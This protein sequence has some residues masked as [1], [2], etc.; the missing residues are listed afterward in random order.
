MTVT[1]ATLDVTADAQTKVYG[2][3]DP[4]LTY[5]ATGFQFSDNEAS[6][7]T[8]A[9]TRAAGEQVA[10][11][12]Y[13][14]NQGTLAANSDYTISFTGN[15]LTITP[16]TLDV[17]ADAQTKVYGAAD[18]TLTYV[19]TGFQFSDNETSVLTGALTRAAGEDVA[20]YAIG[21]G[22]LA[23]NSDYT[24]TFTGNSLTITPATLS[25]AADAQTKVY[26]QA[27]PTLTYVATGFQFSDNEAT[28]LTGALSRAAGEDVASY[29]IGQGTLA[30]NSDYTI[31]FTGNSL[32]ITPATL[33]VAADAQT[34]VYGQADPTLTYVATGFQF[35]DNEATVLTGALSRAVGEDVASYAIGQGTLAANSDYTISFTGNSLTITPATLSVAADVQTKVYGQADPA[36]TYVATG[37]QFSD[38]EATVLTGALSRAAGEDVASYAIG[39]G[40]LAANSDYTISFTGNSL[41]ITPATLDVTADAQTK[42]YGA[43][44]PTLTYV[45]TGFQFSD[46][47]TSVLTGAL[48]RAAGEDVASYAIGQGTLA[49]NSD[50]TISFTGNSLTITP[51]TLVSVSAVNISY[52]T[53]LVNTQLSGSASEAGTPVAGTFAYN[54]SV[55]GTVLRANVAPQSEPVIFTPTDTTDYNTVTATAS[56]NVSKA[57]LSIGTVYDSLTYGTTLGYATNPTTVEDANGNAVSGDFDYTDGTM[58]VTDTVLNVGHYD[59]SVTFYPTDTTDYNSVTTTASIDITK[60]Q[61]QITAANATR[62]YGQDNPDLTSKIYIAQGTGWVDTGQSWTADTT[63]TTNSAVGSYAIQPTEITDQAFL[64]NYD[65]SYVTGELT[66]TP[67]PLTVTGITASDKVY[68]STTTATLNPDGAALVG[69]VN[70]D[71]V[72]LNTGGAAGIFASND[73]NTNITVQVSGLTISGPQA[74]DYTLTQPTT[75]A[76]I[77]PALLTVTGI[78]AANKVYDGGTTAT[79]DTTSAL[80][81]GVVDHEDVTLDATGATGAFADKNVA[82][83][84]VVQVSGL[85]ITGAAIG[86]YTLAQPTTTANITARAITVTAVTDTKVYDGTTTSAATPAITVGTLAPGDTANFTEAFGNKNVGTGKTLTPSGSVSDGNSGNNYAVTFAKNRT[87]VITARAITVTAVTDTKVY[88]GTTTSAATPAITVGTLAPGDTA[89]FTEAFDNK[90]VGTGKRL[91]PS[92]SVSDGNSGNN[93]AVTFAKNRTGVI[94]A[95]RSR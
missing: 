43:A 68:D 11:G 74:G 37:F 61:L 56:I 21:Q 78:M 13:A 75:S 23:A 8:G 72:T 59:L 4:T 2:A 93:Y 36:L 17:T 94:T 60:A 51:A 89:N 55:L 26:G 80:L 45:A 73:A 42:V 52:G 10:G 41:T 18:P 76:N 1:P 88:D 66:L 28:V 25:V 92:G 7:L 53:A 29:A 79:L 83:N 69:V 85:T 22:T 62:V 71:S 30:A 35:S 46:D 50:Y 57:I 27:D 40:T 65:I 6:V 82:G 87:G 33:S 58:D 47:E 67:A 81:S 86:N 31:S 77:T 91:T 32:T 54:P 49:A 38:N 34:K 12:P 16:A 48:T 5:V 64:T 44:D 24:I 15:S 63:A 3:A 90:N 39:Q 19:A 84:I 20:S 95:E 9:L 14:I 70:G